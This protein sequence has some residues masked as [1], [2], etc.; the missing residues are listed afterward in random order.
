MANTE[1]RLSTLPKDTESL[2]LNSLKDANNTT[3]NEILD[4]INGV[5]SSRPNLTEIQTAEA[6]LA[7]LKILSERY[8]SGIKDS[9]QSDNLDE[10]FNLYVGT[11]KR[12]QLLKNEMRQ[13]MRNDSS[14]YDPSSDT[15]PNIRRP[16][17]NRKPGGTPLDDMMKGD[18]GQEIT[19]GTI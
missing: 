15:D 9:M 18:N 17:K 4:T 10:E 11:K 6:Y 16:L 7:N 2:E 5:L 8:Q 12:L 14:M 1:N 19:S 3:L 13:S